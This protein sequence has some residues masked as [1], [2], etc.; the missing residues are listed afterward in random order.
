MSDDGRGAKS[1]GKLSPE[2]VAEFKRRADALGEKIGGRKS[3]KQAEIEAQED[4]ARHS[5]GMAMGLRMST[6]LVAAILVGGFIGWA[7]DQ[8]LGTWPWMFLVFFILGFAAGILNVT[9]GFQKMQAEI[10]R[11][12]RLQAEKP[13]ADDDEDEA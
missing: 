13:V 3:E 10:D 4:R 11:E 6:E 5:R 1:E 2:E 12:K 8:G 7:I 9:R